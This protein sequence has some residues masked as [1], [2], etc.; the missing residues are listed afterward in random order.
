VVNQSNQPE[1][2]EIQ[3][4][5]ALDQFKEIQVVRGVPDAFYAVGE[6]LSITVPGRDAMILR[7]F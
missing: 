7:L 4:D 1:K 2:G 3:L 5:P 6:K